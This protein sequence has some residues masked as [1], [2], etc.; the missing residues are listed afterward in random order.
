MAMRFVLALPAF[1][2]VAISAADAAAQG[3]PAYYCDPLHVYSP[4]YTGNCPVPWRPVAPPVAPQPYGATPPASQEPIQSVPQAARPN[5]PALGDGLDD[6]CKTVALPSSIAICSDR[7]LRAL[8]LERQRAY[9]GAKA[10][11]NPD[12]QKALL[13][14]QNE[15]VRTYPRTCGLTDAPSSLPLAPAIKDCMAEAGRARIAY[16]RS[17]GASEPPT[18]ATTAPAA[19]AMG[20]KGS[21]YR[22]RDPKTNLDY[23]RLQP[24]AT[25]DITLAAPVSRSAPAPT[26]EVSAV[27]AVQDQVVRHQP[28]EDTGY[29]MIFIFLVLYFLPTVIAFFRHHHDKLGIF[30]LDFLL[31]W[32]VLGWI[33]ALVWSLTAVNRPPNVVLR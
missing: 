12:Q 20:V 15:W 19:N 22:C 28:A 2:L 4:P 10:G 11:L 6:W 13:A 25:G 24:C 14:D 5:L 16:L 17:Y 31:G 21:V 8:V 1:V 9:D 29:V 7:E 27:P 33:A 18:G 26:P 23:E 32:T 3:R 30:A